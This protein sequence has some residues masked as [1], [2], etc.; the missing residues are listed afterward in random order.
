[1]RHRQRKAHWVC[2]PGKCLSIF[3]EQGRFAPSYDEDDEQVASGDW[4][5]EAIGQMS[6]VGAAGRRVDRTTGVEPR[7]HSGGR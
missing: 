2:A 5:I 7:P 4:V 3:D 6:D 1:M